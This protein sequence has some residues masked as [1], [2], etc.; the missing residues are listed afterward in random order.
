MPMI[1]VKTGAVQNMKTSLYF[2]DG[3]FDIFALTFKDESEKY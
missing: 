3:Y 2:L 1:S